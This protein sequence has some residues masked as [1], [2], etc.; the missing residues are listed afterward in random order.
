MST[1]PTH[2]TANNQLL[3]PLKVRELGVLAGGAGGAW[4]GSLLP[5][6]EKEAVTSVSV[7]S[8]AAHLPLP[9]EGLGRG[10]FCHRVGHEP[11]KNFLSSRGKPHCPSQDLRNKIKEKG[12][13]TDETCCVPGTVRGD[14]YL[15]SN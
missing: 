15:L 8:P 1:F 2:C 3:C 11:D 13:D 5:L 6:S 14:S 9:Q 12:A 4:V 7:L 10:P